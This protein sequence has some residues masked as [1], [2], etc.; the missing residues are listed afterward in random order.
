MATLDLSEYR[1]LYETAAEET[2]LA[3]TLS[4]ILAAQPKQVCSELV[5]IDGDILTVAGEQYDLSV[6]NRV[7]VLG[8]GNAAGRV[9]YELESLL[10]SRIDDGVI[11]TDDV[12]ELD[13]ISCIAG[14]H[15]I[16]TETAVAGATQLLELADRA[17]EDDLILAV[18]TGG[19]SAL[20]PAPVDEIS[21]DELQSVTDQLIRSGATITELNTVRKHL[22]KIKGGQLATIVSPA[23]VVSLVFSDVVGND[24]SVIASGPFAPDPTTFVDALTVLEQYDI[25]IP[26]TVTN[27]L[28]A[29]VRGE[30]AETPDKTDPVFDRV[31]THILADNHTALNAAADTARNRGYTP[32]ILS[33]RI[34]GEAREAA[35]FHLA[36]AEEVVNT[37]NPIDPPAVL[38]SGG[39]TTVTVKHDGT[40]GPNQE[41]ALRAA[42]SITDPT[43]TVCSVDTDG[44][45]GNADAAGA[46]VSRDTIDAVEQAEVAL[47]KN[48]AY[49]VLSHQDAIV[50]TGPTGTNVNDLRV[51]VI[52]SDT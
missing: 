22:S 24:Q 33:A 17:N 9:G 18:I 26:D 29:G 21:L 1:E 16:P 14:G 7:F 20:L 25:D 6:Y 43:I 50:R 8:G 28:E 48:D 10:G 27:R 19:G 12:V 23:T 35:L 42:M 51:F 31:Y 46:L 4:G 13:S 36:I 47:S 11:V 52:E 40:G 44:I 30:V 38:L 2:A 15:P 39:E 34:Q 37:G 45:D 3:C 5:S 32:I 41:F 49:R